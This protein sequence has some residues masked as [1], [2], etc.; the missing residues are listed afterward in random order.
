[1]VPSSKYRNTGIQRSRGTEIQKYRNAGPMDNDRHSAN[2][3]WCQMNDIGTFLS[4]LNLVRRRGLDTS[5]RHQISMAY[6]SGFHHF[7][8]TLK[9]STVRPWLLYLTRHGALFYSILAKITDSL[10]GMMITTSYWPW[11]LH[12][13]T[14]IGFLACDSWGQDSQMCF[15]SQISTGHHVS[16]IIG[17]RGMQWPNMREKISGQRLWIRR[18]K[19]RK[20]ITWYPPIC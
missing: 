5:M 8:T 3:Q 15:F 10:L 7:F 11:W 2:Q 6:L 1:M 19:E 16:L 14:S 13:L 18:E 12:S 17:P 20:E 4:A 9:C